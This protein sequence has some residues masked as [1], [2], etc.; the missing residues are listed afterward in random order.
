MNKFRYFGQNDAGKDC[1][2]AFAHGSINE[3]E[4]G[5]GWFCHQNTTKIA[6]S[7]WHNT[8]GLQTIWREDVVP[9]HIMNNI[10]T[11]Y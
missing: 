9:S 4:E 6:P 1:F 11:I 5:G 7:T 3:S 8:V 2:Q 10:R